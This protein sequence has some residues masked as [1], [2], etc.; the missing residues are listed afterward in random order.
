MEKY[1]IS[2]RIWLAIASGWIMSLLAYYGMINTMGYVYQYDCVYCEN[3]NSI[4]DAAL[5]YITGLI[6]FI[7]PLLTALIVK[8]FIKPDITDEEKDT[9]ISNSVG[10]SMI[11]IILSILS[12]LFFSTNKFFDTGAEI[13]INV[14]FLGIMLVSFL[15]APSL[16]LLFF[17]KRKYKVIRSLALVVFIVFF[18]VGGALWLTEFLIPAFEYRFEREVTGV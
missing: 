2:K 16:F 10:I 1:K 8:R 6:V 12:I 17:Y 5:I 18:L 4:S 7:I 9:R 13:F 14:I 11:G 3:P 15:Y